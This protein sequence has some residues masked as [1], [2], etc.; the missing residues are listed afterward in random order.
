MKSVQTR[1]F[2]WSVFS[3]FRSEYGEILRTA[4]LS[5]FSLN[6]GKCGP[7]KTSYLG[8]FHA[9]QMTAN[10]IMRISTVVA[11]F[12]FYLSHPEEGIN[13]K[14]E[15]KSL[16]YFNYGWIAFIFLSFCFFWAGITRAQYIAILWNI[17]NINFRENG[18]GEYSFWKDIFWCITYFK[19]II[20]PHMSTHLR[21]L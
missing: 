8:T 18:L 4:Y 5:V 13:S 6:A 14:N 3:H 12:P 1:S 10:M 15:L 19:D 17:F 16:F 2:I 21:L 20:L 7:E 11:D 9:M